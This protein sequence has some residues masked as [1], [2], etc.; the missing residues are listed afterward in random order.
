MS[1]DKEW[2]ALV[3]ARLLEVDGA[4]GETDPPLA[5]IA[6]EKGTRRLAAGA[7]T[8]VAAVGAVLAILAVIITYLWAEAEMEQTAVTVLQQEVPWRQ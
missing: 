2:E 1:H 4:S 5:R 6:I 3:R 8:R 7:S